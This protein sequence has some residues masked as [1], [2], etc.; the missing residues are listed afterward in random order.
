MSKIKKAEKAFTDSGEFPRESMREKLSRTYGIDA[1]AMSGPCEGQNLVSCIVNQLEKRWDRIKERFAGDHNKTYKLATNLAESYMRKDDTEK[2]INDIKALGYSPAAAE[3]IAEYMKA[4]AMPAANTIEIEKTMNKVAQ[5]GGGGMVQPQSSAGGMGNGG[6]GGVGGSAGGGM[7]GGMGGTSLADDTGTPPMDDIGGGAEDAM[8]PM[9]GMGGEPPMLEEP[10]PGDMGG[11]VEMIGE[12]AVDMPMDDMGGMDGGVAP[13]TNGDTVTVEI[14]KEL[15]QQLSEA[16]ISQAPGAMGGGMDEGMGEMDMDMP[17]EG[18]IEEI[19]D[20][21]PAFGEGEVAPGE[22]AEG[23]GE[24]EV[25]GEPGEEG[26][27]HEARCKACG[28]SMTSHEHHEEP[29]HKEHK[30][31]GAPEHSEHHEEKSEHHEESAPEAENK[32]FGEKVYEKEAAMEAAMTMRRGNIRAVGTKRAAKSDVVKTAYE[33]NYDKKNPKDYNNPVKGK[34]EGGEIRK[35]NNPTQLNSTDQ[36]LHMEGKELGDAKSKN[37]EEPKPLSDGNV[38]TEGFSAND[39]KY[40]DHSTMG[41][42]ETFDPHVVE[43]SEWTGGEKSIMG[44]FESFPTDKPEVPAGSSP[45]GNEI[46]DGGNIAT[47]GTVIATITPKGVLVEADGKKYLAPCAIKPEMVQSIQDGLSKITFSGDGKKFAEAAY[48]MLK[49]AEKSGY[50]DNVTKCDTGKLEGEKFTNDAKKEPAEGGAMT[51]KGKGQD[52][53]S[54]D[55]VKTDT[56]KLEG[57][58]FTNDA[59]KKAD[60]DV[61]E[62]AASKAVKTAGED[63]EKKTP[64]DYNKAVTHEGDKDVGKPK[65]VD[66][67]IESEGFMAGGDKVQ[68]KGTLGHEKKFEAHE[69]T[70]SEYSGG[71]SSLQGKDESIPKDSPKVPAGGGQMGHET[72]EGGNVETKGTTIATADQPQ[73]RLASDDLQQKVNDSTVREARLKAAS[74]HVADLLANNDISREDFASELEKISAMTVPA[75][76]NLIATTKM[77]RNRLAANAEAQ[78]KI[79]TASAEGRVPGLGMPVVVASS[80]NEMSLKERLVKELKLTKTLDAIDQMEMRR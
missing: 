24:H 64:T 39:K 20:E 58:K 46:W 13:A 80:K 60:D 47:K 30:E 9:D 18:G 6:M 27:E 22:P 73:K 49:G 23:E 14:P 61:K 15:V 7:G 52:Y 16:I 56:S 17:G 1:V 63:M 76:Q 53:Q 41:R 65:P 79:V 74:F 48:K 70:E 26:G 25:H 75:I 12:P 35:L 21:A 4:Y 19:V 68:D 42:E 38:E 77:M 55:I 54:K 29:A 5:Y 57:S 66:E 45:I 8:P 69:V 37:P 72:W 62:A 50:V 40:Q 78:G 33:N 2:C 71:N 51:G 59:E 34:G 28:Q 32:E 44:E 10:M 43:K 3:G 31:H 36:F 11:D 67:Q